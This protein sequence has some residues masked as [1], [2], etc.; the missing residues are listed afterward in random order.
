MKRFIFLLSILLAIVSCQKDHIDFNSIASDNLKYPSFIL[1]Q[2][3]WIKLDSLDRLS[4]TDIHFYNE[5][6]GLVSGFLSV[7][8]TKDGG[9]SW[10]TI[11]RNFHSIYALNEDTYLAGAADGLYK[12]NDSGHTWGKCDFPSETTIFD[13]WFKDSNTGFISCG[14]G[15][16]RTTNAGET[17]SK[18]TH[19]ISEN[20]QFSSA[21]IGYFSCG[22]TSYP[23][24]GPG[25]TSSSGKIFRT[26]DNGKTWTD[27]NLN[28]KEITALSFVSDKVGFFTTYDG[29]LYK[30]LDGGESFIKVADMSSRPE[31]IFFIDE[32]QGFLCLRDGLFSTNDGGK[33]L[34]IEYSL[35][36]DNR[37]YQFSFPK[38]NMGFSYDSKGHVLKRIQDK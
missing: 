34:N 9:I 1:K 7:F 8:L 10:R 6:V 32:Q 33:T 24:F 36:N 26:L 27:T 20:L 11:E 38:L 22:Y 5:N 12:S 15:T 35:Q 13:I 2:S 30:T 21:N 31:D 16:Y 14:W 3:S 18:V 29:C 25:Q 17:W 4:L 23:D 28:I 37:T 19:V